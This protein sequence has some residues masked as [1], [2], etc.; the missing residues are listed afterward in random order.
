MHSNR[1]HINMR[2]FIYLFIGTGIGLCSCTSK[3]TAVL[4]KKSDSRSANNLKWVETSPQDQTS[5]T[6]IWTASK[7]SNQKLQFY[8]D[9]TCTKATGDLI[10]LPSAAV[11]TYSFV[12]E[13]GNSYTYKL[14][15][16]DDNGNEVGSGCSDIMVINPIV[17]TTPTISSIASQS[18]DLNTPSSAI[19]F[20]LGDTGTALSCSGSFLSLTSSNTSIVSNSNVTWSGS[21]P[22]CT[23]VVTP[24]ELA[25]GVLN[26]LSS[27][28]LL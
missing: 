23:A 9:A 12:G 6:A 22:N 10:S 15:G 28:Y 26:L 11:K 27:E 4:K 21:H 13:K 1:I 8:A 5:I 17:T 24:N 25:W 20:V 16:N 7:L 2:M 14:L 3:I 19:S 18:T